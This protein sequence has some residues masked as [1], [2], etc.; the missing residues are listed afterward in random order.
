MPQT[1]GIIEIVA[2]TIGPAMADSGRHAADQFPV[3]RRSFE[4]ENS[5]N[6]AHSRLLRPRTEIHA[7]RH[8]ICKSLVLQTLVD[9][10]FIIINEALSARNCRNQVP[11]EQQ[12]TGDEERLSKKHSFQNL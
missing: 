9:S 11:V 8:E 3:N 4:V 7:T 6:S 1:D 12:K 10:R 2:F 5:R